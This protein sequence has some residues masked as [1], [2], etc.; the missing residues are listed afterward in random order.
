MMAGLFLIYTLAIIAILAKQRIPGMALILIGIILSAVM[1]WY[2]VTDSIN[3]R[4]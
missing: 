4:L 1:F 3:I 2:H